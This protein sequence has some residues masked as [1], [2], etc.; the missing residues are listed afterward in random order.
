MDR[1]LNY[2][3]TLSIE[4]RNMLDI[5]QIQDLGEAIDK[6]LIDC[7]IIEDLWGFNDFGYF[8]KNIAKE[9]D[10]K[11]NHLRDVLKRNSKIDRLKYIENQNKNSKL[12]Y[13]VF[14]PTGGSKIY[15][16]CVE[17]HGNWPNRDFFYSVTY[18]AFEFLAINGCKQIS[19]AN[20]CGYCFK[21]PDVIDKCAGEA[22]IHACSK[23]SNIQSI[24]TIGIDG[25][26]I[27]WAKD[28]YENNPAEIQSHREII[29][30]LILQPYQLPIGLNY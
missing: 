18:Q 20:I 11:E 1:H 28:Y 25:P 21:K 5:R 2:E 26:K 30:E 15:K 9:L 10:F 19:I 17:R 14:L 23:Y 3:S 27:N 6:S 29:S 12:K 24:T 13:F 16:S 22:M 7:L 4:G 8:G